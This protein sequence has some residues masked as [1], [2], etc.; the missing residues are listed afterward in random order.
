MREKASLEADLV[1]SRVPYFAID[2]AGRQF[3]L[4]QSIEPCSD[5]SGNSSFEFTIGPTE[6]ILSVHLGRR[7]GGP[8]TV[9]TTTTG[10]PSVGGAVLDDDK[11]PVV[12]VA[13]DPRDEAE[14]YELVSRVEAVIRDAATP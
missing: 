7:G 9:T 6:N 1:L 8:S 13:F 3:A 14:A 10:G 5:S 12:Q 11:S 4:L 2:R